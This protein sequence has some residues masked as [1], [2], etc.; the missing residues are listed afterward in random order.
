MKRKRTARIP[1]LN[2][3]SIAM[4]G[5]PRAGETPESRHWHMETLWRRMVATEFCCISSGLGVFMP[6]EISIGDQSVEEL[7]R[8]LVEAQEQHAATADILR[9]IS[10][11]PTDL[12]CVFAA[13]AASATH[14]CN[15]YDAAIHHVDGDVLRLVAHHGP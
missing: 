12:R 8:E 5:I 4:G 6:S 15:A 13:V 1:A 7:R 9:L 14:V 2:P 3:H 11:S 10:S